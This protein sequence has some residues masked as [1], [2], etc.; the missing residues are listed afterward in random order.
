MKEKKPSDTKK[1]FIAT[2]FSRKEIGADT[3]VQLL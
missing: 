1:S 2:P 3:F